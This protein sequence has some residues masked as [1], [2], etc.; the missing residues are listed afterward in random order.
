MKARL[1]AIVHGNRS[2]REHDGDAWDG[3]A[4]PMF[5]TCWLLSNLGLLATWH[6]LVRHPKGSPPPHTIR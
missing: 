5:L 3:E 4:Q 2:S 6:V 1:L